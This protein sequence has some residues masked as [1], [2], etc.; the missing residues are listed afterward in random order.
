MYPWRSPGTPTNC[1]FLP[2][3]G[4]KCKHL[5]TNSRW[6][7]RFLPGPQAPFQLLD[8]PIERLGVRRTPPLE[9]SKALRIADDPGVVHR[10][11]QALAESDRVLGLTHGPPHMV[12]DPVH[13]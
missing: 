2:F 10:K 13:Q 4:W 9:V 6:S 3:S 11:P 1:L 7:L 8:L 12:S 5:F